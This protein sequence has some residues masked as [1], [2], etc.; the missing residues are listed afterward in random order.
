MSLWVYDNIILF[1]ISHYKMLYQG[2]Y[3][4]CKDMEDMFTKTLSNK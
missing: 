3:T 1:M 4:V 2:L